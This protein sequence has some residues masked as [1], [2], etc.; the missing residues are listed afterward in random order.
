MD[1]ILDAQ[2]ERLQTDVIDF[3]LVHSLSSVTW[4]RLKELS[5]T[6]FLDKAIRDG[7][8]RYAGFSFHDT[9]NIF[10]EI[11]DGYDWSFCQIQYNYLDVNYQAGKEGMQ[12]AADKGLGVI[13]MEPLRGG[14]LASGIP[15]DVAALFREA[16]PERSP[17]QWAL[18]W[19]WNHPEIAVVLSG[20]NDIEQVRQNLEAAREAFPGQ[21]TLEESE[22]ISQAK[23]LYGRRIKVN[24]TTCGYCMPCPNRVNIPGNFGYY[25]DYHLFPSEE[26][27]KT[28]IRLFNTYIRPGAG[29]SGCVECGQCEEKCPQGISIIEELKKV[30]ETFG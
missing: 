18:R 17:A 14:K 11:V 29:P 12:Y 3:Y 5:V 16:N 7:K 19:V 9:N 8:V 23:E 2:L 10:K 20:M 27:R 22:V 13:A 21:L 6:D 26:A 25:N 28:T 15:D 1:D 30:T 24:C 4:Q